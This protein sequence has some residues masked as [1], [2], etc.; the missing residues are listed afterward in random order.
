[1][2]SSPKYYFNPQTKIKTSSLT[3]SGFGDLTQPGRSTGFQLVL[4]KLN[5]YSL[6]YASIK[7]TTS[8]TIL[9]PMKKNLV[10]N[11]ST[12]GALQENY[13]FKKM[14]SM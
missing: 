7:F 6:N 4:L 8:S 3:Y 14:L 12:T 5:D 11:Q 1:M 10:K 9:I 2:E 13:N